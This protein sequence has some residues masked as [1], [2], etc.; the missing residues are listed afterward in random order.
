M[1][2]DN[3]TATILQ[4]LVN[5]IE[6]LAVSF[7]EKIHREIGKVVSGFE[8]MKP[9]ATP[10]GP[11]GAIITDDVENIKNLLGVALSKFEFL[12]DSVELDFMEDGI[13]IPTMD[14]S[15][16][17]MGIAHIR[18]E[19]LKEYRVTREFRIPL[20]IKRFLGLLG[21]VKKGKEI[22]IKIEPET[23]KFAGMTIKVSKEKL[24]I[25]SLLN[26]NEHKIVEGFSEALKSKFT[27]E[28]DTSVSHLSD[29]VARALKTR[30]DTARLIVVKNFTIN[31]VENEIRKD[32]ASRERPDSTRRSV[33]WDEHAFWIEGN[34][35]VAGARRYEGISVDYHK[36]IGINL[37]PMIHEGKQGYLVEIPVELMRLEKFPPSRCSAFIETDEEPVNYVDFI[38]EVDFSGHEYEANAQ[39]SL[40][41][42]ENIIK[43]P[44]IGSKTKDSLERTLHFN[45]ATYLPVQVEDELDE[46]SSIT[47]LLAPRV[48]EDQ[49]ED[50]DEF[51]EPEDEPFIDE[52]SDGEAP[53]PIASL[54]A[55]ARFMARYC[56]K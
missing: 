33:T 47:W 20:L 22:S 1:E 4:S 42:L 32:L 26:E 39:F 35:D 7:E 11:P 54:R 56:K 14:S 30:A 3:Q 40:P 50:E 21:T 49:E 48:E 53:R 5:S 43:Q 23:V 15:H 36:T 16:V 2:M 46:H 28:F 12:S 25:S 10:S 44:S 18:K 38:S 51:D 6:G 37:T 45:M 27:H 34:F 8:E 41:F 52:E 9:S 19:S 31:D 24:G 55:C 17:C 29:I 13:H